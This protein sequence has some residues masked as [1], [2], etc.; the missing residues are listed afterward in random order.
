EFLGLQQPVHLGDG[1]EQRRRARG[2]IVWRFG[3]DRVVGMGQPQFRQKNRP[4]RKPAPRKSTPKEGITQLPSTNLGSSTEV[5][6]SRGSKR[7][8]TDAPTGYC[9]SHRR[10]AAGLWL[11]HATRSDR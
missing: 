4:I 5:A 9:R 10:P 6:G 3:H 8:A 7:T 1:A 2:W 11:P